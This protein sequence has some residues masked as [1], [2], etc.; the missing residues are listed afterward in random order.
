MFDTLRLY[1]IACSNSVQLVLLQPIFI[2]ILF[3]HYKEL[4]ELKTQ[5]Q[6]MKEE[7]QTIVVGDEYVTNNTGTLDSYVVTNNKITKS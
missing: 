3:H 5:L 1:I 6:Q 2:S 7:E 4:M